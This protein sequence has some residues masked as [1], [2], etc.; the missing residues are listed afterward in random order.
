MLTREKVRVIVLLRKISLKQKKLLVDIDP[1]ELQMSK[2]LK[3]LN[4]FVVNKQH[5]EISY[6][7]TLWLCKFSLTLT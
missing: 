2:L 7:L 5:K 4:Q 6:L 3:I 1:Y